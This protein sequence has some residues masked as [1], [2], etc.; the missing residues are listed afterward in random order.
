MG[1][2]LGSR[3]RKTLCAMIAWSGV[4]VV[5]TLAQDPF[6]APSDPPATEKDRAS[7]AADKPDD[8]KPASGAKAG[9]KA[10][11]AKAVEPERI[12]KTNEEWQK[13]LTHDEFMVTRM[14]ATEMAFSGKYATGHFKGTFHCVCCGAPLF[15]ASHKFDS[16]TGWPSFDR[17]TNSRVIETAMDYSEPTEARVEVTCR[18]CGAH[19]GHVFQD[20]PTSTGLRYCINSLSLKLDT[21]KAHSATSKS[22][23]T[24]KPTRPSTSRSAR[25]GRTSTGTKDADVSTETAA[26][27]KGGAETSAGSP[28]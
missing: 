5:P 1:L 3:G 16:G 23:A 13:L 27:A 4:L 8:A 20:G 15:E 11:T 17:P 18:R 7:T 6:Q 10:G 21:E 14:K 22:S 19:L 26:E 9:A 28:R 12:I 2:L 25:R 24:K